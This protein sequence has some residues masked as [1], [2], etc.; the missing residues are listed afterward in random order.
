MRPGRAVAAAVLATVLGAAGT[1]PALA[2]AG[3]VLSQGG[4]VLPQANQSITLRG[5]GLGRLAPYTG[6]S[7]F[8][9]IEDLTSNWTAGY[10]DAQGAA[11]G[12][13]V[14]VASWTDT[15]IVISGLGGLYG[16]PYLLHPGD[17]L[18]VQVW[19]PQTG[20]G[21]ADLAT[22][23]V[24][25]VAPAGSGAAPPPAGAPYW[26][27][28]FTETHNLITI[29]C[30]VDGVALRCIVDTGNALSIVVP[31]ALGGQLGVPQERSFS[32]EGIA[33]ETAAHA[34]PG[35]VE[36]GG[37]AVQTLVTVAA[38]DPVP[39]PNIGLPLL[40]QLC[41]GGRG[42]VQIDWRQGTV[43]CQPG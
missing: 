8:L 32:L 7:P 2:S 13:T 3:P 12:V 18:D 41:A 36:V 10:R 9:R 15:Q 22:D 39:D 1:G 23:V 31:P 30:A 37:V 43:S 28:P 24:S 38:Q 11:D 6:D 5:S 27:V 17:V 25:A 42:A 14:E 4:G 29:P 40:E 20:A 19:N 35:A 33:G 26:S 34:G 21:P 16:H